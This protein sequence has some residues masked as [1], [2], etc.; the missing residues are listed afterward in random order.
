MSS[1][2]VALLGFGNVGR[3]FAATARNVT[4]AAVADSSGAICL[5]PPEELRLV[6]AHKRDGKRLSAY[7]AKNRI[8]DVPALI[9][10]LGDMGVRVLVESLPTNFTDGQ[11]ALDWLCLALQRGISV[12]TVDKGPIVHGFER[13]SAAASKGGAKLAYQGTT[14]IWPSSDLRDVGVT[15]IEGVLN[16]T[17]NYILSSMC[18]TGIG[19]QP[20]LK[21]AQARGIAEPDP[22]LDLDGWDTAAKILILSKTLMASNASLSDVSRTGIGPSTQAMVEKARTTGRVVRLLARA[23]SAM[24]RIELSVAPEILGPESPF[25]PVSGTSK[26]GIFRTGTNAQLFVPGVSGRESISQTIMEDLRRIVPI[27]NWGC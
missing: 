7:A 6:S 3:S 23:H 2:R 17:T 8:L 9:D 19:F 22:R 4:I 11:P 18:E 26:A 5:D 25:Y 16:G 15:E 13:L 24:G 10:R 1:L 14:G 27:A 12:V 20:A 21:R